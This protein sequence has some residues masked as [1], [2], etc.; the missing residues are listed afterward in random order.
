MPHLPLQRPRTALALGAI[1]LLALV[2]RGAWLARTETVLPPL[3]DPQ[4]YQATATNLAAGR[5]YSVAVRQPGAPGAEWGFV[6]GSG[7]E[8]T[9][10]WSPGYPFVLAPLYKIFGPDERI[11]KALNALAGALTVVPIFFLGR[12]IRT[13]RHGDTVGLLAAFLFAIAPSLIFWTASLFSEALFTF[14]VATTLAMALWA[15]E[16]RSLRA[17]FVIGIVLAATA[18]V[19]AQGL[20][21]IVPVFVLLWPRTSERH[22]RDATVIPGAQGASIPATILRD[23][24]PTAARISTAMLAGAALLIVPWAIRND[25]AMGAPSLISDSAGYNLRLAHGPYSNGTSTPPRDL[26]DERPGISFREREIFWQD[27]GQRRAVAYAREHPGRELQLAAL[28]IG[29]LLRSDAEPSIRWSE[30]LGVTPLGTG[31]DAWVLVGDVYWYG[32]LALAAASLLIVRRERMWLALWSAIAVWL[33]LH[34]VFAGEPRYHVPLTPALVI[35]AAATLIAALEKVL[36]RA[37]ET[38]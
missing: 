20:L 36:G 37:P 12:G 18:F 38:A 33:A 4:Y 24:I 17:Y 19:R 23:T 32:L 5:G 16:R 2:L 13:G 21:F 28:R 11:A 30:S 10:F 26:W 3:S 15:R 25:V 31:R 27:V 7:S 22:D 6:G 9:A 14:G 29:W 35:L 8:A 1:L 34:L